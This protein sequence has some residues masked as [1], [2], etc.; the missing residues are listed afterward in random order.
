MWAEIK[1]ESKIKSTQNHWPKILI[2]SSRE[3]FLLSQIEAQT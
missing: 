2:T 3:P 1:N